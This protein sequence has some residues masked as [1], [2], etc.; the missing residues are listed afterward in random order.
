MRNEIVVNKACQLYEMVLFK[1][2]MAPGFRAEAQHTKAFKG[3]KHSSS[4]RL[5][6]YKSSG[7]SDSGSRNHLDGTGPQGS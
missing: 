5:K 4:R 6:P 2:V 7:Y 1:N 3:N